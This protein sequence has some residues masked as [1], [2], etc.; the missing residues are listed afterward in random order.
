MYTYI[1]IFLCTF[2]CLYI[3][4]YVYTFKCN[5]VCVHIPSEGSS[6]LPYI[7]TYVSCVIDISHHRQIV[8]VYKCHAWRPFVIT[9]F[10]HI[11]ILRLKAVRDH[12]IYTYI[13]TTPEGR[14]WSLCLYIYTYYAWRPFVITIFIHIYIGIMCS[15]HFIPSAVRVWIHIYHPKAVR[16]YRIHIHTEV[17]FA[18][19]ILQ[20]RQF[21]HIY[22]YIS[23][24]QFVMTIFVYPHIGL[25]CSRHFIP[26]AN[27]GSP[28][29]QI[30]VK[31]PSRTGATRRSRR[32]PCQTSGT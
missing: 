6:W 19:D 31:H 12:Y 26:S 25:I 2:M 5:C 23:Q 22:T 3:Y 4:I 21:V 28:P 29:P 15:R 13:H 16:D 32:S 1:H 8:R 30:G 14:S 18:A 10:I 9:M 24:R 7:C 20:R 17:L 11:C 27:R